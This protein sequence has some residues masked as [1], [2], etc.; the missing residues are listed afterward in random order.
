[1]TEARG[2]RTRGGRRPFGGLG[3]TVAALGLVVAPWASGAAA[4]LAAQAPL[5]LVDGETEVASVGFRFPEGRTLDP[6][7]LRGQLSLKGTGFGYRV[8]SL[9]GVLP[10]VSS[11]TR[12]RFSPPSL[13][14]DVVRLERFYRT[15]GFRDPSVDYEVVLDTASNSVDVTFVVRE[16]TPVVLDTVAVRDSSGS[17]LASA[18]PPELDEAWTELLREL[19][20]VRGERLGA[21]LRARLGDRVTGWLRDRG[22]PFPRLATDTVTAEGGVRLD[23]DV[24]P[25]AR[26]RVGTVDVEGNRRLAPPVLRREVPLR[27]GDWFSRARLA[28]GQSE[29]MGLDMVRLATTRVEPDSASPDRVR[30]GIRVTEGALHLLSGRVGYGLRSGISSDLSW[31]HRDFLGGARTLELSG[32]ARTGLLAPRASVARRYG[33]SLT[34]RQPWLFD[35]R[36]EGTLRPFVEYRDDLRDESVQFGGE[37][38]ALFRRGP[39]R[40][41]SIRY[42]LT[43]RRIIAAGPGALLGQGGDILDVLAGVDTLNL[44]RRTSSLGAVG[45]WARAP[46]PEPEPR[47]D[48]T[49]FASLEAAGPAG[50][51]TVEYGKIVAEATGRLPLG[52]GVSVQGRVGAGRVF[53]LGVSVPAADGSDRLETYLKLR[54]AVLTAGGAQ[55]VRG[56]GSELLG[57]KIPDVQ[58]VDGRADV[59]SARYVPLGGLARW[60]AS[61]QLELPFPFLGRPHGL[62][63]FVD[64]GRVWTPDARF[65]PTAEPILPDQ[66]GARVRVGTGLGVSIGT[67]V[68]PVQLDLGFK[69]NPST[70]DLRDPGE[71]GQALVEGR[72]VAE[73]PARPLRRWHL[74]LSIGGIS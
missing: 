26:M 54:D 25:G 17:P 70:L 2:G 12:E 46:S 56:W 42:S 55:D 4:P 19:A 13:F 66:L 33:L 30:V 40:N 21:S 34:L 28:E 53:P 44:D 16:G 48:W 72:P 35:H 57:P 5:F 8:R 37:A 62:H 23:L 69:V 15:E 61:L 11:P 60:T 14:R 74:H 10:L 32:L 67:P 59:A 18:L 7:L 9:L 52:S 58:A 73:V 24:D 63:T 39:R 43:S 51:S 65:L 71:V 22:Y 49:V 38:S 50:L 3:G 68:G 45:R 20:D 36:V 47:P 31:S 29:L 1:M 6:G 64:A 41:V 27:V